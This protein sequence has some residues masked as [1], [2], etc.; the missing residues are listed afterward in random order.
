MAIDAKYSGDVDI[1]MS[2]RYDLGADYW[3]T[4]DK[5][6]AKGS[7]FSCMCSAYMLSELGM[8]SSDPVLSA[9]AELF[10]TTWQNDGRFKLYPSG[11]ILPCHTAYAADLMCRMGYVD[12]ERI[13][14]TLRHFLDTPYADGGWRC[15]KFSFGRGPET[16]YSNPLPTLNALDAFRHSRYLNNEP[17]LDKAVEFL[18]AHWTI[19]TPIGPCQYGMGTR[20]MQV[21]YPLWSYNLFQ[22][23]YVLSFYNRAKRDER[24]LEALSALQ[25]KLID[26]MI[27][28]E[29]IVPKLSKL[30]FC[31]KGRPSELA[32]ERYREI[33]ENIK[34]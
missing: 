25:S 11:G 27:V 20:F 8:E 32:T 14:T 9:V 28:V 17:K 19:R 30:S 22:Y 31:K 21:E 13:Q 24:F 15:N 29:R 26:G 33:S 4:P 6:L 12:D 2:H 5:R 3:T 18:L 10:F 23:V 7:P 1:I 16:D 34:H